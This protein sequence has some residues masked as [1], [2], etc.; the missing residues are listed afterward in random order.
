MDLLD[1]RAVYCPYCGEINDMEVDWSAGA[2][3]Y[4]EDCQVCCRPMEVHLRVD[5]DGQPL[6]VDVRREDE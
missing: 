1:N 6:T 2:G 5:D 3:H 4:V